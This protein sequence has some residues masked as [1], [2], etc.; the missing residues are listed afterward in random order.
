MQ[1]NQKNYDKFLDELMSR[2]PLDIKISEILDVDDTNFQYQESDVEDTL[3]TLNSY[4]EE[5]EFDLDKS[6]AKKIIK[7][8]YLEAMEIE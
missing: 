7:D 1:K 6:I 4:I 2:K 5:S 8:V 3:T